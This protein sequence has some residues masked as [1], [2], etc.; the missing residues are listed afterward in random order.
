MSTTVNTPESERD[1]DAK[2]DTL[3]CNFCGFKSEALDEYLAHSCIDVIKA[4]GKEIVQ[5]DGAGCA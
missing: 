3:W 5:S 1:Q 4:S 2:R